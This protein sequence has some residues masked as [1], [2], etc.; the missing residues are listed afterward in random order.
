MALCAVNFNDHKLSF[1]WEDNSSICLFM[2]FGYLQDVKCWMLSI[3]LISAINNFVWKHIP[4]FLDRIN[5]F[6]LVIGILSNHSSIGSNDSR[7]LL[8]L[9][10][11]LGLP[12][13]L[14]NSIDLL[15]LTDVFQSLIWICPNHLESFSYFNLS[16]TLIIYKCN[17][18]FIYF[19]C[20]HTHPFYHLHLSNTNYFDMFVSF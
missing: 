17:Y 3:K 19:S 11:I 15:C 4:A 5:Y 14:I 12:L 2:A 6:W 16:W 7:L 18:L 13:Y 9:K 20:S 1:P 10:V 8:N